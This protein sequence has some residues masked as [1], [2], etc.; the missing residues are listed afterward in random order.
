MSDI[1]RPLHAGEALIHLDPEGIT[2]AF[3]IEIQARDD[4][5]A[6][7]EQNPLDAQ[8]LRQTNTPRPKDLTTDVIAIL[9][10]PLERQYLY[11]TGGENRRE[12]AASDAAANDYDV[13]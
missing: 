4:R 10:L 7:A 1:E 8:L 5:R 2:R 9:G 13:G 11:A 6:C 3:V 12:G